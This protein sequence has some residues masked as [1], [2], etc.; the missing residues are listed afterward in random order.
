M[1][2]DVARELGFKLNV[3]TVAGAEPL[4]QTS[5]PQNQEWLDSLAVVQRERPDFVVLVC[6][7]QA[8]LAGDKS[9]LEIAIRQLAPYTRRVILI[10][11]PPQLP[12]RATREA[13]RNGSRPP[14][15]EDPA[16]RAVRL[17]SNA[18]VK[19]LQGGRVTVLD[20]EALFG[21]DDGV[22]LRTGRDGKQLYQDGGHLSGIGAD[23]VKPYVLNVLRDTALKTAR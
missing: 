8:K 10:T 5:G 9:K 15:R 7:W 23:M 21:S 3:I 1:M 2:R 19:S 14:F 17:Q 6:A 4:P 16:E 13:I 20:I 18:V 11:E 12:A 22:I